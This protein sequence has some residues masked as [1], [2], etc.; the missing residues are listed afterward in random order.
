[1]P[2]AVCEYPNTFQADQP[3][4]GCDQG[5]V[6]RPGGCGQQLVYRIGMW[7]PEV[8]SLQG[9]FVRQGCLVSGQVGGRLRDPVSDVPIENNPTLLC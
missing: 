2:S 4:V 9:D 8:A 5:Q 7:K 1:M 6:E 3:L